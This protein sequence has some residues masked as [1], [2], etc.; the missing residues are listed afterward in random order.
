MCVYV[1]IYEKGREKGDSDRV[2]NNLPLLQQQSQKQRVEYL[3]AR[4]ES[5]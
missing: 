3:C 1:Y 5:E 2:Y 4:S